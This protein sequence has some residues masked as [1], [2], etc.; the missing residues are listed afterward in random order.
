MKI[1]SIEDLDIPVFE[2][3]QFNNVYNICS[4]Y[5]VPQFG[6]DLPPFVPTVK[7][8]CYFFPIVKKDIQFVAA[9]PSWTS[10]IPIYIPTF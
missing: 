9:S 2:E 10:V 1:F 3:A 6:K 5:T 7:I 8:L 4:V